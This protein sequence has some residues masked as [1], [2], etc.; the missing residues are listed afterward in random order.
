MT[1][2]NAT[3]FFYSSRYHNKIFFIVFAVVIAALITDTSFLRIYSISSSNQ[4][5]SNSTLTIF[6]VIGAVY[7]A[8]QFVILA[9]VKNNSNEIRT[10]RKVRLNTIHKIVTIVQSVSTVVFVSLIFEMILMSQ[11][12]TSILAV[13]TSIS[14]TLAIIMMGLLAQW[15]FSWYKSNRNSVVL[16]YGLASVVLAVN[17]AFT[18][19]LVDVILSDS[20]AY[21]YQNTSAGQ[22]PFIVPGSVA[23]MLN[24]P[25]VISSILSF[26]FWWV[27]TILLLGGYS[28]KLGRPKYWFMVSIPLVYFLSQFLPLFPI[29]YAAV[30]ISQSTSFFIYNM[31]FAF[32][33]SAGGILFGVAFWTIAR[34]LGDS[35]IV[36]EYM[37]ISAYGLV[38]L[39]VS[40][41]AIVL[42][43][44]AYPPFGLVTASFMG[45]S[46]Y[47]LL[48]GIYSS[49]ISVSEDSKLRQSIRKLALKETKLLDSIGTAQMQGEIESM[50]LQVAK[51]QEETLKE[52][53]GVQPS[54]SEEDM[55]NYLVEVLQE[56]RN[57]K[58]DRSDDNVVPS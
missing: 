39:F 10:K 29:L 1:R 40:N 35:K 44:H 51:E 2:A 8:G 6:L 34:S 42:V 41:Q 9:F 13:I 21:I 14:Y 36:R 15:F 33:K 30:P 55:K 11:Y 26:T 31:I 18:V 37:I 25:F 28:K 38:L 53:T 27:G 49:A 7:A 46:S 19:A 58:R 22:S 50:V 52:Q 47:L 48:V 23:D 43:D 45:L 57:I 32:S 56:V 3:S 24:Y 20:P 54:L 17:A 5:F 4:L 12:N 16:F